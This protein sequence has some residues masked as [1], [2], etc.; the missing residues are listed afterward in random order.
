MKTKKNQNF[1]TIFISLYNSV[2]ENQGKCKKGMIGKNFSDSTGNRRDIRSVARAFT[3]AACPCICDICRFYADLSQRK[4]GC[5]KKYKK[6]CSPHRL[7]GFDKS[8]EY[9]RSVDIVRTNND[10]GGKD[11]PSQ[12]K[13]SIV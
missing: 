8:I 12:N 5:L 11:A 9:N 1:T 13:Q 4:P 10:K 2:A 7:R 3:I 6:F